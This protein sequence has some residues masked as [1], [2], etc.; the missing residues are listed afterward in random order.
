MFFILISYSSI[1]N[2]WAYWVVN[3]E[4]RGHIHWHKAAL[5]ALTKVTDRQKNANN[6]AMC[7]L[8]CILNRARD[9]RRS[10]T[11]PTP[12]TPIRHISKRALCLGPITDER[13][14]SSQKLH[15]KQIQ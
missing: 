1:A 11:R 12:A 4:G 5:L 13:P 2:S 9:A 3:L 15:K 6:A 14:N 10:Y 7:T 8:R